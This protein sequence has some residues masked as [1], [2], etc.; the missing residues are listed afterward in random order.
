MIEYGPPFLAL[1]A[2]IKFGLFLMA[3]GLEYLGM[4]AEIASGSTL[5]WGRLYYF[6]NVG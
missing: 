3:E 4:Q 6:R 2:S 1:G 5:C